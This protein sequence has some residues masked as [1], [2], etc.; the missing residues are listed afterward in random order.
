[1]TYINEG[2]VLG[3]GILFIILGTVALVSRCVIRIRTSAL[4]ADDWLA[5]VA[6]VCPNA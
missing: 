5:V 3:V 4:G 2:S 1:M 6:W